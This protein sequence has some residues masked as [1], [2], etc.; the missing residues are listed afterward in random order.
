MSLV[1]LYQPT[2]VLSQALRWPRRPCALSR[3][4]SSRRGYV[5]CWNG[6]GENGF[7]LV[8]SCC[9][10]LRVV[11]GAALG[12]QG[13]QRPRTRVLFP[14]LGGF[15][16]SY[17]IISHDVISSPWWCCPS[18]PFGRRAERTGLLENK[19]L[20]LLALPRLDRFSAASYRI[21]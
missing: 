4:S 20:A 5:S 17:I 2:A 10:H 8:L 6:C 19:L 14:L 3:A 11:L 1:I 21:T 9:L 13:P 7:L 16:C 18:C 15:P 12:M